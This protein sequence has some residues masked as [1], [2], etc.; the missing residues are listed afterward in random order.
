MNLS[1]PKINNFLTSHGTFSMV[2]FINFNTKGE[3]KEKI[4]AN[5][6]T[7]FSRIKET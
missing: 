1:L 6:G 4:Y 2:H 3:K 5:K 7:I